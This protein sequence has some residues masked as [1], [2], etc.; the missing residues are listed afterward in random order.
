MMQSKTREVKELFDKPH[1]YLHKD[2]SVRARA[3]LC[4][5]LLGHVE[6]TH[7]LDIGAGDGSISLQFLSDTTFITMVDLS[8]NMLHIARF[9]TPEKFKGNVE[10]RNMNILDCEF[11]ACFEIALCIGV[12]AHVDSVE[13]TVATISKALRP[14]G[15]CV[16]QI[17]DYDQLLGRL[18]FAYGKVRRYVVPNSL[19]PYLMNRMTFSQVVSIAA[20]VNLKFI[21]NRQYSLLLPGMGT[22]PNQWL[23]KYELAT[24]QSRLLSRFGSERMLLLVKTAA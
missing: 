17:T 5:E 21:T 23:L 15:R 18:L 11:S 3:I 6:N 1:L 8:A 14:G 7:I 9:N 24:S 12:L 10:H 13:A 22:L 2:F 19:P 4:K 16:L 20:G